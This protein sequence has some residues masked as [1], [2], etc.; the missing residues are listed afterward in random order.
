MMV[1]LTYSACMTGMKCVTLDTPSVNF[2][3]KDG[4]LF[5]KSSLRRPSSS[6]IIGAC[7]KL[8]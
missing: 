4:Y 8:A 2:L 7:H 5:W 3:N 1:L 6:L